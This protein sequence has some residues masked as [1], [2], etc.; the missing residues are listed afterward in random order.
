MRETTERT[1]KAECIWRGKLLRKM[2]SALINIK[3]GVEDE[4]DRAYFG[5]TND[6]DRFREIVHELDDFDWSE[7]IGEKGER[8]YITDLR[9]ARANLRKKSAEAKANAAIIASITEALE[10][11]FEALC[12]DARW[13]ENSELKAVVAR[14]D[15][16]GLALAMAKAVQS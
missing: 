15:A 5:S 6:A 3:D 8:D 13:A 12:E 2:R 1:I 7:I 10:A 14:R 4:G 16:V 9:N 11:E